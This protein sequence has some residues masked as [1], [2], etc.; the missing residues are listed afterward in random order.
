MARSPP[1]SVAL[2]APA[3]G[4]RSHSAQ[5]LWDD[6]VLRI[7]FLT[8]GLLLAY[9]LAVTLRQPAWIGPITDWLLA[10][11]A[12]PGL[13]AVVLFSL[14]LTR[15]GQPGALSWWLVSGGLFAHT[16]ARTLWLVEDLFLF[17]HHVPF[18]AVHDLFFLFQYLCFLLALLLLPRVRPGIRR[19]RVALDVCLLLGSALALCWNFLLAPMSLNS[20]ATLLGKLVNLSFPVG[21][22]A[23]F[24]GLAVLLIRYREY[25]VARA[26]VALL[27]A[28]SAYLV[29]A[30]VWEAVIQLNTSSYPSGSPPD[31]F[32]LA[33]S[34]LVPLAG[35]VQFRLTQHAPAS[36]SARLLCQ[37]HTRLR[38]HDLMAVI[39][40]TVPMAAVLLIS[41]VLL[42]QA[43]LGVHNAFLSTVPLL[44]AL[45]LLV[46]MLVRQ[47]LT[48]A[49]NEW[50]R[51]EREET[52]WEAKAQMEAFL[53]IAGH[54]LKNPLASMKLGLQL[55][56]QRIQ[57]QAQ[58]TASA[59][60]D[61]ERL[62][63]PLSQA[64]RQEEKME[65]LVND[66]L[67]VSRVQAG[68]LDLHLAPTDLA[69]IVREV[70]AELRQVY[71]E[72]TLLLGF[73]EDLR[74]PVLADALRLGQV[75]TNYLT[76]AL[77]YSAAD[78]SVAVDLAAQGQAARV[79]VRDEGPGI[80]A[81]EQERIWERYHR[82]KG[83]EVRSGTGVGLGLGLPISRA[84]IEQHQ[85]QV[86]VQSAPGQGSTFWF[87]LPLAPP[88]SALGRCAEDPPEGSPGRAGSTRELLKHW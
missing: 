55:V 9:Q 86:G 78:R 40:S 60:A 36:V 14:W 7:A 77:K 27:F 35:L 87:S 69:A 22:L 45:G 19:A 58:H 42:I 2:P 68:K 44:I 61:T 18:P 85:G 80:P 24:F 28:A 66:L 48:V 30:D 6:W 3:E 38:R 88:E 67:D 71:P 70:V 13:L 29:V 51:R 63:G 64:E 34:L 46:L 79:E 74:V 37:P 41:T 50:L 47:A 25:A 57:H 26:V 4:S 76:N 49:D 83:I 32:W 5:R 23:V 12:W 10:L 73:P 15:T 31:L 52:L 84:I 59:V 17:P 81:R 56:E 75:V 53:G 43:D 72:R 82:V 39:R 33:F 8:V 16:L 54:E 62:L 20:G 11:V 65:Q 1:V 21:A